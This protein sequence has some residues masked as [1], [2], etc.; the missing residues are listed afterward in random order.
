[1]AASP[2]QVRGGAG[3]R[4]AEAGEGVGG[5]GAARAGSARGERARLLR[6]LAGQVP[7]RWYRLVSRPSFFRPG[8]VRELP[9]PE[10]SS[11]SASVNVQNVPK[12]SPRARLGLGLSSPNLCILQAPDACPQVPE[13][14]CHGRKG[15]PQPEADVK[16]DR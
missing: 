8:R 6:G 15:R 2:A 13:W 7:R 10:H 1:M 9:R 12:C 5:C 3:K 11:V 14:Q 4:F 16:S